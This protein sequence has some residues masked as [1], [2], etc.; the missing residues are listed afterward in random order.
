M[1]PLQIPPHFRDFGPIDENYP[2][3]AKSVQK[4]SFFGLLV[5]KIRKVPGGKIWNWSLLIEEVIT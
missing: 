4:R 1:G 3:Y 5:L 2:R